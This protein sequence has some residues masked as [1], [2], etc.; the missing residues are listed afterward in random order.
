MNTELLPTPRTEAMI[1]SCGDYEKAYRW[2]GR[3]AEFAR[4]LERE[5]AALRASP[6]VA[7]AE[8]GRE[9]LV[10]GD[11]ALVPREPTEAMRY[12]GYEAIK[13]AGYDAKR[14]MPKAYRA[15]IAAAPPATPAQ[16]TPLGEKP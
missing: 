5:L 1:D 13:S 4:G 3:F 12:A 11:Y 15:M 16:D 14:L 2:R 8:A 6:P 9:A 7:A 10:Q